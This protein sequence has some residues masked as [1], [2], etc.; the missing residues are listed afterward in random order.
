MRGEEGWHS[1]N[2]KI[3]IAA[4]ENS[5][6]PQCPMTAHFHKSTTAVTNTPNTYSGPH[7]HQTSH[8]RSHGHSTGCSTAQSTS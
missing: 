5:M 8:I 1:E 3:V 6:M 2:E 7:P 4:V